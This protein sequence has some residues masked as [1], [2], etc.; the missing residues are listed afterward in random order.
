MS[1]GAGHLALELRRAQPPAAG[2]GGGRRP[3]PIDAAASGHGVGHVTLGFQVA[4]IPFG[5]DFQ[6]QTWRS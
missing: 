1:I 6:T 3:F 2:R 4:N 5:L